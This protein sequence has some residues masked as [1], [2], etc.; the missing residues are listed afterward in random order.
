MKRVLRL[1]TLR[2]LIQ[3]NKVSHQDELLVLLKERGI[4][5]T[6]ATLSRDLRYLRAGKK[7]DAEKGTV[8]FL[9]GEV[10]G[11]PAILAQSP[12]TGSTD[13][14]I[15]IDYS[16]NMAVVKTLPGHAAALAYKIDNQ[17]AFEIIGTIAGDDTIL[18]IG[19]EGIPRTAIV[20]CLRPVLPI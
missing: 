4:E 11:D 12:G 8:Y 15:S 10:S 17:K 7:P 1:Q 6:Q 3:Y 18:V 5:V 20:Q 16:Y 2:E 13:G 9:Q 14:F 19:R